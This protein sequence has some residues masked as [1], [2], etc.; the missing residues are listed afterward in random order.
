MLVCK[1]A[2]P[3]DGNMVL[4]FMDFTE[5][6]KPGLVAEKTEIVTEKN[7][8]TA[9]GSGCIAVYGTPAMIALMETV[10]LSAVEPLLPQGWATV[11][12]D[13]N[14]KHISATPIGMKV[15][16][17]AELLSMDGRALVFK[18][19][20]SDEAGKIGEGTHTRFIVECERF[21]AKTADKKP[22]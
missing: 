2:M 10:A 11:G 4:L 6:L 17:K 8:A 21:L 7:I 5:F 15:S 9:F 14:I 13:L 18:V 22:G 19:E 12:T 3:E 16:A 20:A 1:D